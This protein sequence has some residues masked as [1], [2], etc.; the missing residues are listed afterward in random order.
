MFCLFSI[1]L[2]DCSYPHTTLWCCCN[3]ILVS[4]PTSTKY[5]YFVFQNGFGYS[6]SLHFHKNCKICLE[7]SKTTFN[8]EGIE[9]RDHFEIIDV[10]RILRFQFL[11][12]VS[13]SI[14][15]DLLEFILLKEYVY[16]TYSVDLSLSI[17]CFDL[18]VSGLPFINFNHQFMVTRI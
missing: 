15:L 9:P 18:T 7:I 4:K 1:Y 12:I 16:L 8:L 10:L 13:L 3:F 17:S 14:N 2:Y 5:P 11:N 6:G